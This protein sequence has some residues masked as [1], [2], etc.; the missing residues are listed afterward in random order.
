MLDLLICKSILNK[1]KDKKENYTNYQR[2]QRCECPRNIGYLVLYYIIQFIVAIYSA[3][4]AWN[5]NSD[6]N[7]GIRLIITIFAFIFSWMYIIWYII[8]RNMTNI[9]C[10]KN[11]N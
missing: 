3:Y 6:M 7:G 11:I 5:C 2:G 4:L 8:A 1:Y 9:K 10:S